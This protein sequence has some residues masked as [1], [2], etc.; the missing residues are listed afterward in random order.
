MYRLRTTL[1]MVGRKVR[2]NSKKEDALGSGALEVVDSEIDLNDVV[3]D[4]TKISINPLRVAQRRQQDKDKRKKG[5]NSRM[6]KRRMEKKKKMHEENEDDEEV[7]KESLPAA[8]MEQES[9]SSELTGLYH[10]FKPKADEQVWIETSD[11]NTGA[12]YYYNKLTNAVSWDDPTAD[13]KPLETKP[14]RAK[15]KRSSWLDVAEEEAEDE[16]RSSILC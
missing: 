4:E 1:E 2:G 11:P 3:G 16:S 6:S 15:I 12:K 8:P 13:K 9:S 5:K 7:E 14:T 10:Q